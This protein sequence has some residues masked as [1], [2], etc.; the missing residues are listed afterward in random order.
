MKVYNVKGLYIDKKVRYKVLPYDLLGTIELYFSRKYS[1]TPD[2][3]YGLFA[4]LSG[5]VNFLTNTKVS[6]KAARKR[7]NYL[8][9]HHDIEW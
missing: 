4:R 1:H 7:A 9:T 6:E 2:G 8:N 5:F 3:K